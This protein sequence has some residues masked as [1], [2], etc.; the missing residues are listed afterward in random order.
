MIRSILTNKWFKFITIGTLYSLWVIWL[1]SYLWFLGLAIIFDIYITE[2]VH[3]AFWKKKNPP[4]GK[5]TKVVEWVDAII[6]AV[7]AATFIRMFFIEAYTIPTSSMEKSMLVG[8]YLF[9]SKTA[10]GP[11]TPNTPLSFPFVHNTMPVVGGKSY[12]EAITR[13]YKR[14]KGFTTIKNNDVVVFHF[15][16]GDTVAL[17]I[18]NQSYYQLTRTYGKS[19]V[20]S[21][22]RNFGEIIARPV[23]KRENYI[24]RC[25]GI[26]GDKI[27]IKK[28]QL[29]VNDQPQ[30]KFEGMQF[31]YL[32]K[33]NGTAIN[34]KALD[35]LHI[36]EDDR[37]TYS[38]QQYLFPLTQDAADKIAD[39]ANVTEV[40]KILEEPGTWERNI[41]PADSRYPWNVDNFGPLTI[42]AKGE[43]VSLT[44][45][46][47]PLYRRIIDIY[48][49]NDLVVSGNEIKINGEVASSYT[50]KMDYYWMMGD[51][52]HNSA[53]SRYWGFVPEDH[54]VGKA[55]FI[56]LSLDKDKGFPAN[57]RFK[58]LFTRVR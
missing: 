53:D 24:K 17:G 5:Q 25:V 27:E 26:P 32:V 22:K 30:E 33:T 20:W 41:F 8:D 37:N 11:K 19:R 2:K 34:P 18:P 38:S 6:F 13:P 40:E 56:W 7:I 45:D 36:A 16:E 4:N 50:F 42:P 14:L 43:T 58:R 44:I 21:D 28:G 57:I 54:V 51:N 39:F 48:E 47:L 1:G 49:E 55:K 35:K 3:W 29:F 31:D 46:N 9:V 12:S 23:D 52:R 15:P 10:Y